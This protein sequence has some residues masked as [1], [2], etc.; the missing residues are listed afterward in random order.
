MTSTSTVTA[1]REGRSSC[2]TQGLVESVQAG[3]GVL[4]RSR[5]SAVGFTW[6]SWG[7]G[8]A[9]KVAGDCGGLHMTHPGACGLHFV[10][11][12]QVLE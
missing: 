7:T 9:A 2:R 12:E 5:G 8:G 4:G 3:G 10:G 11:V 1:E 6:C